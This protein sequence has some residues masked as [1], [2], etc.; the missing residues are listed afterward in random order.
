MHVEV[1]NACASE[2]ICACKSKCL[3]LENGIDAKV[4]NKKEQ[5]GFGVVLVDAEE[6][7][8]C[9]RVGFLRLLKQSRKMGGHD[10]FHFSQFCFE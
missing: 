3:A 9:Q 4:C 1:R 10:V 8:R 7:V 5:R 6:Q 2:E